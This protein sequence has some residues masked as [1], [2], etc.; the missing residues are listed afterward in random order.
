MIIDISS[1]SV[2]SIE[3]IRGAVA[4]GY[5]T[6]ENEHKILDADLCE[7]ISI[8]IGKLLEDVDIA[9]DVALYTPA[10][11]HLKNIGTSPL[12]QIA[13]RQTVLQES[14]DVSAAV[15]N[16]NFRLYQQG[17]KSRYFWSY[18]LGHQVDTRPY[19]YILWRIKDETPTMVYKAMAPDLIELI[20][21]IWP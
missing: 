17:I 4:R 8:E 7:A 9:M 11:D 12:L 5:C 10:S 3:N 21:R 2:P 15:E 18:S 19:Y 16:L 20:K 1:N 13:D 6:K 14:L